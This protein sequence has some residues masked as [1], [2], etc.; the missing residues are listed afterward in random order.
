M[1]SLYADLHLFNVLGGVFSSASGGCCTDK[2]LTAGPQYFGKL[3]RRI[4]R[5]AA[6][7]ATSGPLSAFDCAAAPGRNQQFCRFGFA[8]VPAYRMARAG[9]FGPALASAVHV[10]VTIVDL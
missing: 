2:S 9:R 8:R 5:S 4:S 10:H 3:D 6:G 7:G 1:L